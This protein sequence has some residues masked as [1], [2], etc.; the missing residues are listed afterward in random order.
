MHNNYFFFRTLTPRLESMMIG[1]VISECFSQNKDE[2]VIRFEAA[3]DPLFLR[4]VFGPS[5][6]CLSFPGVFHRTRRNSVDLFP[7]LI[8]RRVIK[9][10]QFINERSFAINLSDGLSLLFKMH[11]N[12]SNCV[13]IDNETVAGV[14]NQ[15]ITTD[16]AINPSTLDRE[17]DWSFETFLKNRDRVEAHYF[18]FGKV[19]W[20]YLDMHGYGA[21]SP[22][23]QW[24]AIQQV[25]R[26]LEAPAYYLTE[27]ENKVTLSLLPFP[28]PIKEFNDPIEALNSFYITYSQH[29]AL[30]SEKNSVLSRLKSNLRS[31]GSFHQKSKHRLEA[32]QHN[33]YKIWADLIMANLHTIGGKS[34]KVTL[35]NFYD[36]NRPL[37]IH[38]KKELSPQKNAEIY[39]TKAKKQQV[40]VHMLQQS[41]Q[42]KEQEIVML[43]KQIEEA[44]TINDIKKL[45]SFVSSAGI[46]EKTQTTEPLPYHDFEF[47]GFRILVGKNAKSND[48]LTLRHSY[49]D[50]LWLHAKDVA[51]SHVLIKHQA[52][53]KIPKDVI[54]R[55]AQ[56]AAYY[57]KRKN[58]TLCPVVVTPKKFV[59]KRK[60]DPAG[61]VVVEKE[62]TILVEPKAWSAG[63]MGR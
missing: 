20:R 39:Y 51:G 52:G 44:T 9:I 17:I 3:N 16:L 22:N 45:R 61:M 58:E 24:E 59:R 18:T 13:L 54:E 34:D 35:A 27:I 7:D 49:K 63:E 2:L 47:N 36:E 30:S 1:S 23:E 29:E 43:K 32:L 50:D 55:A 11:G 40:E 41:I 33:N 14:F 8:G 10:R 48:T 6:A 4:A 19:V 21:K 62:D 46:Q 25:L 37:E 28:A 31:S 15:N 53:K 5:F 57:S 42:K 26:L 12:R 56:L 60:G 38:L